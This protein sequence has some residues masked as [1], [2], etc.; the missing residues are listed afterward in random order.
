MCLSLWVA[1][2]ASVAVTRRRRVLPVA[3]LA[4]SGAACL[5]ERATSGPPRGDVRVTPVRE[6]PQSD[7]L[8]EGTKGA[9][10]GLV[11]VEEARHGVGR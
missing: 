11:P 9:A 8:R 5:L 6:H 4:L 3:C 10:L 7:V 1:A 2:P